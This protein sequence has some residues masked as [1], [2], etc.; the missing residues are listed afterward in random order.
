[1]P[2]YSQN[3]SDQ[4]LKSDGLGSGLPW[5]LLAFSIFLFLL[6]LLS[7]FALA[8]GYTGYLNNRISQT[9]EETKALTQKVSVDAQNIFVDV[10]SRLSNFKNLS[11]NHVYSTKLFPLLEKITNP[12]VY[13][14]D[15]DVSVDD[16]RMVLSGIAVNF[17]ALSQQLR[18]Y[19]DEKNSIESYILNQSR[20]VENQV[21]FRVTLT[22]SPKLFQK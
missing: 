17:E 6:S 18:S 1:M 4:I 11:A 12:A 22:L 15:V 13:Y 8:F 3:V 14:T 5:R 7:Y 16:R 19:D 10:Y 20:I 9:E 2:Q 21:N